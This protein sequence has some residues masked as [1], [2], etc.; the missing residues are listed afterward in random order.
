MCLY[1]ASPY[2]YKTTENCTK[3]HKHIMSTSSRT[4]YGWFKPLKTGCLEHQPVWL[5]MMRTAEAPASSATF[6]LVVKLQLPRYTKMTSPVS[7]QTLSTLR[8]GLVIWT[9][10]LKD[11]APVGGKAKHTLFFGL[12]QQSGGSARA[13]LVWSARF[14][15]DSKVWPNR[16]PTPTNSISSLPS[17]Q[18]ATFTY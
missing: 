6:A 18:V 12:L 5:L 8:V 1:L 16:A 9:G 2:T 13:S 14:S 4:V 11:R 7:Y 10:T 3:M 17:I 15:F